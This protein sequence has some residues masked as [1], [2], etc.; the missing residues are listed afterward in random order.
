M[1][2]LDANE[3]PVWSPQQD[4]AIKAVSAWLSDPGSPQVFRLFGWAGTGKST[5]AM[6][7][8]QEA[9][10]PLFAAFTG[11]AALVMRSRGC[12]GARTIHSLIYQAV[13]DPVTKAVRFVINVDSPVSDADLVVIDEVS[14]V[15]NDLAADLLS[16][17]TKVLVLGDPFQ[18]PPINDAGYFTGHDPDVMLTEIHRQAADNPIIR[19]SMDVR[20]GKGLRRGAYGN[21]EV[22]LRGDVSKKD[23][24]AADQILVG[25]N[26]TRNTYNRRIRELLGRKSI[27]PIQD[28]KLVCLRNNRQKSLL[29]G[30]I[31]IVEKIKKKTLS[32]IK[33]LI[34]PEDADSDKTWRHVR[35]PMPF[36]SGEEKNIDPKVRRENEEF[37]FGYALTVHKSQGSQW[38]KVYLFDESRAFRDNAARHLY[39]GI[40]RAAEKITVVI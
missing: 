14:M 7:L 1:K 18:L 22:V 37:C 28:D 6:H 39:T 20:E 34:R 40:T 12:A 11:K 10:N 4:L 38:P 35:V 24:L 9:S 13:E 30:Q 25:K 26:Q 16:F 5:L 36:F 29:N 15:G 2:M 8:A 19:M 32:F 17:G 23:V 31:F 21:S 3:I 27:V 33:L